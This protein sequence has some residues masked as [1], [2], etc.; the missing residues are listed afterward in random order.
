MAQY[1][2]TSCARLATC[3]PRLRFL[4]NRVIEVTD[5]TILTG[6]R[7]EAEQTAAY[8]AGNSKTP[9]PES[10]HNRWPSLAVDATP[11]PIDWNDRERL[12]LFAGLVL[13]LAS[14]QGLKLRWGGD[15]NGDFKVADNRFDDLV[16]FE[17]M[18]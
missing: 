14:A 3:D 1:S 9:W 12:T 5:C 15:W 10:K 16:H 17:I 7:S 2:D 13:G 18:E 4:F 11:Y 6:H 8:T